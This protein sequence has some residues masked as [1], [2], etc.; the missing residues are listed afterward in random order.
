MTLNP[1]AAAVNACLLVLEQGRALPTA[2]VQ[3]SEALK[4]SD[5]PYCQELAYGILRFYLRYQAIAKA[6]TDKPIKDITVLLIIASGFY[7]LE[8]MRTAKHAAINETVQLTKTL[9]KKWATKLVNALLRRWQRECENLCD[10]SDLI[11][12]AF[13]QWLLVEVKKAWP[14]QWQEILIQS[15]TKPAFELRINLNEV[16]KQ[17]YCQQLAEKKLSYTENAFQACGITLDNAMNVHDIPGFNQGIVSI[18]AH[19]AQWAA[20]LLEVSDN[21]RVLDACAAPGGKTIH[22][23]ELAPNAEVIAVD[24]DSERLNR[25]K[26]NLQRTRKK[27]ETIIADITCSPFES[28]HFD[29]ILLD[30]PCS[31]TGVIARH[32]D[33]KHLRRPADIK[34]LHQTQT[35]AIV[36][37]WSLLKP[38]GILVYATCSILPDENDAII[39]HFLEHHSD[40][41]L[42]DI[43]LGMGVKTAFGWQLLPSHQSTDGFYVT[44]YPEQAEQVWMIV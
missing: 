8:Y 33:I 15:N 2:L 36:H 39:S 17:A 30:A 40:A 4:P 25:V 19:G 34:Q 7:Q 38:N 12:F 29:R 22:I 5:R 23:L 31:A 27:A 44:Q 20:P 10:A 32:P 41:Q 1:R 42:M 26:E 35:Q 13:P 11:K 43:T 14:Q 6:W 28:E 9:K 3:V 21:M 16:S 24:I 18:Q 37:A